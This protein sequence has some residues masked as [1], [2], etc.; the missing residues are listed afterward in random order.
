MGYIARRGGGDDADSGGG[1]YSR[2]AMVWQ[3][4]EGMPPEPRRW[5]DEI[6]SRDGARCIDA[7]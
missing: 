6:C 5:S 4:V 2:R 7:F 3:A 1:Q